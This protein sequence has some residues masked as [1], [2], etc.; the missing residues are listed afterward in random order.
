ML[1]A[2][3]LMSTRKS[4]ID[5]RVQVRLSDRE[6]MP[7]A[8]AVATIGAAEFLE[9]FVSERDAAGTSVTRD[10]VNVGFVDK[11][12]STSQRK[13]KRRRQALGRTPKQ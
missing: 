3:S 13:G 6:N 11:F 10:D 4:E 5:Q 7:A 2:P 8:S 1:A 12:Q 9:F